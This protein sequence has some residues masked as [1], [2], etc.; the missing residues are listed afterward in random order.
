MDAPQ[1]GETAW[2]SEKLRP[3]EP[4]LRGYL[5]SRF[6]SLDADDVLQESYLKLL[7]AGARTPIACTRAYLFAIA[8]NTALT[9]F[10]RARL[11]SPTPINELPNSLVLEDAADAAAIT[12]RHQQLD[13]VAAA[14][15]GLPGRCRAIVTLA[16]VDGLTHNEIAARL[17]LAP[18]TVRVQVARGVRRIAEHLRRA[19]RGPSR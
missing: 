3:H 8:R 1:S 6:P 19:D 13:L 5:R 12:Q 16:V 18:A 9:L 2:F 15:A 17:G 4:A 11:F 7:R 10:R 14:I